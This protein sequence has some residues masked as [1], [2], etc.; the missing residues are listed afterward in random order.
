MRE[1]YI[2]KSGRIKRKDNTLFLEYFENEKVLKVPIPIN[3]IDSL[4]IFG[5]VDFNTK[6]LNYFTQHQIMMHIFNYYGFYSGTYYPREFLLSGDLLVKQVKY[7]TSRKK[8]LSIAKEFVKGAIYGAIANIK[9]YKEKI[10]NEIEILKS[11]YKSVDEQH[12]IRALMGVEGNAKDIYYSCFEKIITQ[13]IDFKKRVKNPPDNMINAL[14]SFVNS[15]IYTFVLK[16]IYKTQLNPTISYLHEPST[17]RFSLSL[18][19]AEIF[20]PIFGDRLI[21]EM[22]NDRKLSKKDFDKSLNFAY[23]KE[24]GRKKVI[25]AFEERMNRTILHKKFRK[26]IKYKRLIRLELYKLIKHL[27]GESEYKHFKIWW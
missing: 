11:L 14:L 20:K 18:D 17:R 19:I 9:R 7:F 24:E 2:F 26:R 3:D 4:Y 6:L 13:D 1:Y 8:R 21:F 22:L 5:E 12:G 10:D 23:L 16:E 15:L 25:T 27:L